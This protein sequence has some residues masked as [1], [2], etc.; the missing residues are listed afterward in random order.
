MPAETML[1]HQRGVGGGVALQHKRRKSFCLISAAPRHRLLVTCVHLLCLICAG[2][3]LDLHVAARE[4]HLADIKKH[5]AAGAGAGVDAGAVLLCARGHAR[6]ASAAAAAILKEKEAF[7][8]F[9][10][11]LRLRSATTVTRHPPLL[12]LTRRVWPLSPAG[13]GINAKDDAGATPLHVAVDEGQTNAALLL[14]E[15][16]ASAAD[17]DAKGFSPLHLAIIREDPVVAVALLNDPSVDVVRRCW[18]WR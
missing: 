14:L 2:A 10:C 7:V 9:G 18:W 13:L 3:P 11:S 8:F 12:R 1:P 4:G 17:P 5:I 16:G 6:C 15:L